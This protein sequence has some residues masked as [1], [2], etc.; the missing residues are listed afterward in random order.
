VEVQIGDAVGGLDSLQCYLGINLLEIRPG[1]RV[2]Q[3][4]VRVA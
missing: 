3:P 2:F 4:A 1:T